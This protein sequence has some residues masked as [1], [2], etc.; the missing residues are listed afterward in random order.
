MGFSKF[1]VVPYFRQMPMTVSQI[2]LHTLH[3]YILTDSYPSYCWQHNDERFH[4][5]YFAFVYNYYRLILCR[6]AHFIL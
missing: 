6:C 1:D 5:Y 4:S 2:S 3:I